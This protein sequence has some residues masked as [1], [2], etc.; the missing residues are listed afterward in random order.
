[1]QKRHYGGAARDVILMQ[2]KDIPKSAR[3]ARKND[4]NFGVTTSPKD[5]FKRREGSTSMMHSH[6]FRET[7]PFA[8]KVEPVVN[9][10]TRTPPPRAKK[11][12]EPLLGKA[13]RF[14]L[15]LPEHASTMTTVRP[16]RPGEAVRHTD[17][18][19]GYSTMF[20]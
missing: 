20:V 16:V 11:R 3:S 6:R 8:L 1:M 19:A 18:K 17:M 9:P 4:F 7:D 13:Q 12:V 10:H 2:G 14:Y 5:N 15:G